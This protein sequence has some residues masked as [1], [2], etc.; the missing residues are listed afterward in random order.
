MDVLWVEPVT[1]LQSLSPWYLAPEACAEKHVS[2]SER[3]HANV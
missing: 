3:T 2:M 1:P